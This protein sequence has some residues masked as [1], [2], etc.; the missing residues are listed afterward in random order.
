MRVLHVII[1]LD[2]GGA[3]SMLFRLVTAGGD[4]DNHIVVSLSGQGEIG[5]RLLKEGVEVHALGLSAA[6]D[7]ARVFWALLRL[8][9]KLRPDVVQTWMYHAD[10]IGGI[11]AR[12]MGVP[13]VWGIRRT[14]VGVGVSRIT[15]VL[16][17]VSAAASHLVPSAIVAAAEAS[18]SAHIRIGYRRTRFTVIPNGFDFKSA[19][20]KRIERTVA[21]AYFGFTGENVVIGSL[22][23]FNGAKNHEQFVIACIHLAQQDNRVRFVL[24]GRDVDSRNRVLMSHIEESGLS[25]RFVLYGHCDDPTRIY[26]ALDFFCLHSVSEGFPN[27]LAEAMAMNVMCVTTN[28]GDALEIMGG[29][30]IVAGGCDAGA[31]AR[32]MLE[33]TALR[34][35]DRVRIGMAGG[36]SVR[37]RFSIASARHKY[38]FLYEGLMTRGAACDAE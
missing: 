16:Q 10:L 1:G 4:S 28:V 34:P 22:G 17:Y 23:R 21:K 37:S 12:L 38:R 9:K 11:A 7:L 19:D 32:A 36:A 8:I 3:E 27:V 30:G 25:D 13:V 2:V 33:A 20:A 14:D 18:R 15:R 24:A 5:S 35:E 26:E 29:D 6:A 31:L